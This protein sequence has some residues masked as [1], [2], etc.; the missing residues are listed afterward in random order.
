MPQLKFRGIKQE[1]LCTISKLLVDQLENLLKCPRSYFTLEH[2]P[3]TFIS[4][5]KILEGYPFVEVA[6][7]D[8]GQDTQDKTAEII[9]SILKNAGYPNCDIS[10]TLFNKTA[11]YENGKHF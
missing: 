4:E 9:T 2:I 11:Y 5:G 3:S 10:F 1:A 6:W 7:F 8:G